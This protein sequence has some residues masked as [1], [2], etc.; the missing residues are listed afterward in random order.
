MDVKNQLKRA[1][2]TSSSPIYLSKNW[3][4]IKTYLERKGLD[5]AKKDILKFIEKQISSNVRYKNKGKR[6]IAEIGKSFIMRP[7]FFAT[8]Q[9]DLLVLSNKFSYGSKYRYLMVL[10]DQLSRWVMVEPVYST[11]FRHS[12]Q[13]FLNIIS[14]IK[15]EFPQFNGGTLISDGGVEFTAKEWI[16]LLKSMNIKSNIVKKGPFRHS[17]GATTIES[18]LRRVRHNLETIFLE[19]K[20]LSFRQKI[21]TVEDVC[22]QQMLSSLGMSAQEALNH[23][24]LDVMMISSSKKLKKRKHL[25]EELRDQ[26]TVEIP[27]HTVVRVKKFLDKEF[28]QKESYPHMSKYFI[29]ISVDKSRD[30]WTY[31]LGDIFTFNPLYGKYSRAEI[32]IV[33]I[34]HI[35][36]CKKEETTVKKI[37]KSDINYVWYKIDYCDTTFCANKSLIKK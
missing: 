30:I 37:L 31:K 26:P 23:S 21:K 36:A 22:N 12:K 17:K 24:A 10:I 35:V 13:A 29:I 28:S 6:K 7:K 14:R 1:W 19:K 15:K 18:T 34:S 3:K 2:N 27:L 25:R 9:I 4:T 5:I 16:T 11:R 32:Q 33:N 20:K 8:M